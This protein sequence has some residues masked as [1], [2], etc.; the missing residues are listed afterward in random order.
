MSKLQITRK[1]FAVAGLVGL[2]ATAIGSANA[3]TTWEEDHPRRAEV[4]ARLSNQNAR[5]QNQV[6][7]GNL[8]PAQA[9][10]LHRDDRQIRQEERDMASQNG[11][12]ITKSEQRTLNQQENVVSGRIGG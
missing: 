3:T 12:H 10:N 9:A 2:F 6:K 1:L 5:I 8:S 7:A 4:N 11:G